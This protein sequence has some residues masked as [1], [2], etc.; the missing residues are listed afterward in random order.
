M[1]TETIFVPIC[2][3]KTALEIFDTFEVDGTELALGFASALS[4]AKF[5][6]EGTYYTEF[7]AEVLFPQLIRAQYAFGF[8]FDGDDAEIFTPSE[9][10]SFLDFSQNAVVEVEETEIEFEEG[11]IDSTLFESV[12]AT[13]NAFEPFPEVYLCRA[14]HIGTIIVAL[15]SELA[16]DQGLLANLHKASQQ[17]LA[18]EIVSIMPVTSFATLGESFQKFTKKIKQVKPLKREAKPPILRY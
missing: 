4:L 9:M 11:G 16:S 5:C 8:G 10:K 1:L 14:K 17:S 2:E 7:S 6:G 18:D 13:C 3:G 15:K 12:A